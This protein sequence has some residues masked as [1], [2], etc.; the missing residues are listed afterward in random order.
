MKNYIFLFIATIIS[1][2][3]SAQR[4]NAKTETFKVFGKCEMCKERIEQTAFKAKASKANWDINTQMLTVSFDSLK[5]SVNKIKQRIADVGHDTEEFLAPD[6]VYEKLPSCCFYERKNNN[7]TNTQETTHTDNVIIGIVLEETKKGK[8]LPIPQATVQS[9]TD[10]NIHVV[11]DSTGI[12]RLASKVPTSI[13]VS[14]VGYNSD[15]IHI[16]NYDELKII[17]KNASNTGLTEVVVTSKRASTYISS[18]STRNTLHISSKELTK[19]A[20]CNLSES[21]ETSPSVDV[22]YADAVTGIKQIQLLG[23]SGNYSQMLVENIP[24]LRGLSGNFGLTFIPGSWIEG[25]EV[26]KG[27]GSVVNGYES[28]AGQINIEEKKPDVAEKL[29]LNAY[30]NDMGRYEANVNIAHKLNDKWSTALLLHGNISAMKRDDNKDGFL[31]AP[32]GQQINAINRWKYTDNKGFIFQAA[33]KALKDERQAGQESFNPSTDKFTTNAYGVGLKAEQY[34][35]QTKLSYV[36]PQQKFKSIGLLLS[37]SEYKSG[38]YYG[39]TPYNG[40]QKSLYANLIYQ[41][42]IGNTNHKF[43]TGFSW[44]FDEYKE[45][46]NLSNYNRVE[47]VPGVFFEYTFSGVE[48]LN[49][50]AGIRSDF[51]NN[52]GTQVTPRLHVKYAATNNTDLRLSIGSGFRTANV[53]AENTG[54]MVSARNFIIQN[55]NNYAYGLEPEKAWNYGIGVVQNFNYQNR[56]GSI[57]VDAYYSHFIK[58]V[59]TDVDASPHNVIFY[60][61]NGKSYSTSIQAEVNYPL[62]QDF[63]VRVAYRFLDVK[64]TYNGTLLQKSLIAPHRA[65]INLAYEAKHHWIF[66]FTM[67]W[68]SSKRLPNTSTNPIDKQMKAYS[69]SFFL[70]NAQITKKWHNGLEIYIGAEN[71]G[72]FVQPNVIIDAANPFGNYFDASMIW[73]PIQGR[74]IYT[75]LR[76]KIK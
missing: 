70:A 9:L 26:T 1:I 45:V 44:Q 48:K 33:I 10:K 2:A 36:F 61:L 31:D 42:I 23:L 8:L 69:P 66:D 28:I 43:R 59:V 58:Q 15:T 22:S 57:S 3:A 7:N 38:A 24:A 47:N 30:A 6:E 27:T 13:I 40:H 14:Y 54:L 68:L 52:Y 41:S 21:F 35:L 5:T 11:T 50:I 60:N 20:C 4:K 39:L 63:D 65:F 55:N 62:L 19:A 37:A 29:L 56:K 51:H 53:F 75:G 46:Y 76:F 74:N 67:Q 32:I 73:G 18:I 72:S 64:T 16:S 34:E 25:I 12:F 71:L 17:L 49:I